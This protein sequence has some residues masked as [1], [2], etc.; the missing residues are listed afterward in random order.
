MDLPQVVD[1]DDMST[2][3]YGDEDQEEWNKEITREATCLVC[4]EKPTLDHAKLL[5]EKWLSGAN[6]GSVIL[7]SEKPDF[8]IGPPAEFV[9]IRCKDCYH[10]AHLKCLVNDRLMTLAEALECL[11]S[12]WTCGFCQYN[13]A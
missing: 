5:V 7:V 11:F 9:Y 13:I 1:E 3:G 8:G 12:D 10:H 2:V 4:V 6:F